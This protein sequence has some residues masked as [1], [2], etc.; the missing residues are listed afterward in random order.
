MTFNPATMPPVDGCIRRRVFISHIHRRPVDVLFRG[1]Q[2]TAA[3]SDP[4]IQRKGSIAGFTDTITDL[5]IM[6]ALEPFTEIPKAHSADEVRVYGPVR[7][8]VTRTYTDYRI[9]NVQTD[10]AP[11]CYFLT[12]SKRNT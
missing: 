10:I 5:E 3:Q 7:P 6:L 8:G 9:T 11:D 1:V 2:Y 4:S 12:L